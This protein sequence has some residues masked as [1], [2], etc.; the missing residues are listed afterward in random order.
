MVDFVMQ[1]TFVGISFGCEDS[2]NF[3]E[4]AQEAAC[5]NIDGVLAM[6]EILSHFKDLRYLGCIEMFIVA[7]GLFLDA[8][9]STGEETWKL[10]VVQVSLL[11]LNSAL[12]TVAFFS[13]ATDA[14]DGV[15]ELYG[16]MT[17]TD[18]VGSNGKAGLGGTIAWCVKIHPGAECHP[19]GIP[20]RIDIAWVSFL[21]IIGLTAMYIVAAVIMFGRRIQKQRTASR[22]ATM[23]TSSSASTQKNFAGLSNGS[24]CQQG[25][26]KS[27]K[28]SLALTASTTATSISGQLDMQASQQI[29]VAGKKQSLAQQS[30]EKSPKRFLFSITALS[31]LPMR[32]SQHGTPPHPPDCDLTS[33]PPQMRSSPIGGTTV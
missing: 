27:S 30:A 24:L 19:T 3:L 17:Q 16:T 33:G 4:A 28:H 7:L 1:V 5:T 11:V 25:T 21:T 26:E 12:T 23:A 29:L 32:I 2:Y 22:T 9:I 15:E 8:S 14:Q 18:F 10:I 6:E 31:S 20:P 13:L